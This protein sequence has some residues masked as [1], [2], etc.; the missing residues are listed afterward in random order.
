MRSPRSPAGQKTCG[1]HPKA[2][3][4]APGQLR[5]IGD[6]FQLLAARGDVAARRTQSAPAAS[7]ARLSSSTLS[8]EPISIPPGRPTTGRSSRPCWLHGRVPV[9]DGVDQDPSCGPR[10]GQARRRGRRPTPGPHPVAEHW[11][12][13]WLPRSRHGPYGGSS[14][15][16]ARTTDFI[17]ST[18]AVVAAG[19]WKPLVVRSLLVVRVRTRVRR[20]SPA[21][22][23]ASMLRRSACRCAK[24]P[25]AS[26]RASS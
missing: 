9:A 12:G 23:A 18:V 11:P 3:R 6:P 22:M 21:W 15:P 13:W 5:P 4:V 24:A 7:T 14:A 26:G 1:D 10:V 2:A 17:G 19:P 8:P 20:S 16:A 25:G